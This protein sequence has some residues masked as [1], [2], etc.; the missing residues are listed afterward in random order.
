[1]IQYIYALLKIY[2]V[3]IS[4]G[5]GTKSQVNFQEEHG[6]DNESAA[7]PEG[8]MSTTFLRNRFVIGVPPLRTD[9]AKRLLTPSILKQPESN[10]STN[11]D[12]I[13]SYDLP[14]KIFGD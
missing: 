7:V 5:N 9:S 11:L 10:F 13:S 6:G 4:V 1:M 3:Q 2:I 12:P 14:I 8:K